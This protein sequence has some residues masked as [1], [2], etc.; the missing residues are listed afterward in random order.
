MAPLTLRSFYFTG[1]GTI[2]FEEFLAMM[3]RKMKE[4]DTEDEM[5]EAFRV[6]DKDG[7]GFISATELRHVMAN[8]GEKLTDEEVEEMIR[9][10]DVDGDGKVNYDGEFDIVSV[11]S[12]Q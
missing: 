7:D 1:N 6:F 8:L 11:D 10:A 9:E 2:D 12:T 4:T 3:S 5:R